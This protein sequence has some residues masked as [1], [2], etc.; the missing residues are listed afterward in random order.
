MKPSKI[1]LACAGLLLVGVLP[2]ASQDG[3]GQPGTVNYFT[4]AQKTRAFEAATKAG[5]TPTRIEAFQD[6]NFFLTASKGGQTYEVT[7]VPSGQVYASTPISG[8]S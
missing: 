6:G 7:I 2:A 4:A 3:N 8:M 5:Y 1:S